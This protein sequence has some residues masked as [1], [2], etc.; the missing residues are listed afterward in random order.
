MT[1]PEPATPPGQDAAEPGPTGH[2]EVDAAL[3]AL[4]RTADLVPGEQVGAYEATHRTLSQTLATID[5][6]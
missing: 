1:A 3:A 6:G 2:P 4:A 5:Q